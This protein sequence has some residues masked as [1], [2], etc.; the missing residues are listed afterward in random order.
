MTSRQLASLSKSRIA[1]FEQCPKR[2]W[3]SVHRRDLNAQPPSTLARLETGDEV[4]AIAR[5]LLPE[6]VLVVAQPDLQA[7]LRQTR[8]LLAGGHNRPIFEATF[9]HDNVLVQADILEPRS[10]RSWAIAEVKSS[11]SVKRHHL[12]DLATQVWV[13]RAAG[14][15]ISTA[16]VR[17]INTDFVL[18]EEGYYVGLLTDFELDAEL[19]PIVAGRPDTAERARVTLAGPEPAVDV[20]D[21]CDTPY[22]CEFGPYCARALPPQAEWPISIL[23]REG[24][25]LAANWAAKGILDLRDLPDDALSKPQQRII[26]SATISGD[27]FLD[28]DVI[29]QMT[30]SWTWPRH[31]LDFETIAFAVPRW[32]GTRPYQQVPFQ[33]SCH[34][35]TA[36]GEI[37]HDAFL[38]VDGNDPRRACAEALI[39]HLSTPSS[40]DGSIVAYNAGFERG[41]IIALAKSFSDLAGELKAIAARVVDLLPV[42]RSGYYHRDQRGSW[43][44]KKVLPTIAPELNYANLEVGDGEAAQLA[45]REAASP[46]TTTDRRNAIKAALLEYCERDTWAMVVLLR[47]LLG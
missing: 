35:E 6:G 5:S 36:D 27:A 1:A 34:S 41:C 8:D 44:I 26:R 16:A 37:T 38:S 20:G 42:T 18:R 33:F 43:S 7:A 17:H 14:L 4:G 25:A 2:L 47:R 45:W 13:A 19:A 32:I 3:L 31:Y 28:R 40:R 11:G 22:A 12:S 30:R 23:P 9:A 15:P 46:E 39:A 29:A 10:G 21:H 24:R